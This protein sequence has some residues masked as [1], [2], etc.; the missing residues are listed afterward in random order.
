MISTDIEPALQ[1]ATD[2][3]LHAI[4]APQ[5][6]WQLGAVIA[7]ILL[8]LFSS[9]RL[10]ATASPHAAI[11]RWV[12][13]IG[14][15]LTPALCLLLLLIATALCDTLLGA[16]WLPRTGTAVALLWLA[17][18]I[19]RRLHVG[20]TARRALRLL[21]LPL[22]LLFFLG[23][24]APVGA[25][26]AAMS[27]Q[28]GNLRFS[29]AGLLRVVV[30][31]S[32]L[33]WLGWVSNTA[34]Q[35]A[36]RRQARLD[37]RT[38]EVAAKLYQIGLSALVLLLFLQIMGISLTALAV[39]SGAVGVGL[40]FGLQSIASNFISGIIILFDRSLSV[41]DYVDLG[42]GQAGHV[43]ELTLRYTTL[44]GF[45]GKS[46]LVPNDS[47]ITKPFTNWTHKDPKQR[48]QVKFSVAYHTDV[49]QLC[50]LI[51]EVAASHPQVLSG[52]QLPLEE[53]PDCEIESFGDSGVN[54]LVE[55]W[56]EGVDD[57]PNR[58]GGD[59]LLLIFETCK[60]HG[61]EMPFPQREVRVVRQPIQRPGEA[62]SQGA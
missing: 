56:M 29:V 33:F 23:W 5:T 51:R 24:L 32:L 22:V 11:G 44:E 4:A 16:D 36:I 9:K 57:G 30:F 40:G 39:F 38:R 19:L 1:R 34:G 3:V 62:P 28:V 15:L 46:V 48:Y 55:F 7:A 49:R 8:G 61:I 52:P 21:I 6:Y 26:L 31:G 2:G 54:M 25:A 13:Q 59:L 27:I 35:T 10:V 53:R 12:A 42:E 50:Q 17:E 58:V 41:G 18:N 14:D 20:P 60:E 43:R 37:L 47:F 45:D